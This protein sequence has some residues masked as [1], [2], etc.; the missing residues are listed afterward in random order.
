MNRMFM[1]TCIP[2]G[3]GP[4]TVSPTSRPAQ[5]MSEAVLAD[6]AYSFPGDPNLPSS[7][8]IRTVIPQPTDQLA[9]G[10]KRGRSGGRPPACDREASKQ[11]NTVDRCINKLR[12]W[13]GPA[14]RH[15]KT[16]TIYLAAIHIGRRDE[17]RETP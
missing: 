6:K 3:H 17:P 5:T 12:W 10:R 2:A 7:A 11:R 13:R 9:K 4:L 15:D 14:T 1:P 8:G 16:V